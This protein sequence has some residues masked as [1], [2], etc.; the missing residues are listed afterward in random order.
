MNTDP[1][2][3]PETVLFD[4][5]PALFGSVFRVI[6]AIATLGIGAVYFWIQAN[7]TKYLITSQRVVI[8]A[9]IFSK[10][11]TALELYLVNDIELEKPFGQRLMG[12]GNITLIGEDQTHPSL[13]LVRLP[14]DVRQLYEQLRQDIEKCK[15]TRRSYYRET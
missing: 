3:L 4:G 14:L 11:I 2:I 10:N 7:N 8:E 5:H 15:Y 13:R 9:G 6:I 12:T 1:V